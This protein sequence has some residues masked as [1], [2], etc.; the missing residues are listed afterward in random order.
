MKLM[1]EKRE[2]EKNT[3]DARDTN[4]WRWEQERQKEA[5]RRNSSENQRRQSLEERHLHQES[6][7]VG[8][9]MISV[10]YSVEMY[11]CLQQSVDYNLC[12]SITVLSSPL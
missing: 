5:A 3:K 1:L 8:I 2:Q 9:S 6:R 10:D 12:E 4:R 7:R 11:F